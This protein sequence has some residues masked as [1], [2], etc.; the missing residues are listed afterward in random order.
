MTETYVSLN[1]YVSSFLPLIPKF[2][3]HFFFNSIINA[4]ITV[5]KSILMI[6][7]RFEIHIVVIVKHVYL[8]ELE[9]LF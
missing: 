7:C 3:E 4:N 2:A 9:Y 8:L 1:L 6:K 5:M